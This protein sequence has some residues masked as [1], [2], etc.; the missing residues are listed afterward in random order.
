[1][2]SVDQVEVEMSFHHSGTERVKVVVSELKLAILAAD[3]SSHTHH[4]QIMI[5]KM[6]ISQ[7]LFQWV[8]K[9]T[10]KLSTCSVLEIL[11]RMYGLVWL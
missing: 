1:M 10:C 9:A 7:L 8:T 6:P 2:V 4:M 11:F 5:I 3:R